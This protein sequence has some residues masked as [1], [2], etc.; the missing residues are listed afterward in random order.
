[1]TNLPDIPLE[2]PLEPSPHPHRRPE[3]AAPA[4]RWAAPV[5]LALA[6]LLVPW[7]VYLGVVLPD[8]T[9]SRHWDVAWV[10]FDLFEFFALV[11]T[12]WLA[13][14]RSTWVELS[15]SMT[16]ALLVVDAWFDITT[17]SGWDLVQAIVSAVVLELPLAALSIWIARHAQ[18]VS[19]AVTQWLVERSSRQ[20][21]QLQA[22]A[23]K[24]GSGRGQRKDRLAS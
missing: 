24:T 10:G 16:A 21:E 8:H 17:A 9:T 3:V 15:A 18:L 4:P 6:V 1:M 5:Y 7:I 13:Y 2:V 14:R 11:S 23:G 22:A 19:D 20:A 12:A